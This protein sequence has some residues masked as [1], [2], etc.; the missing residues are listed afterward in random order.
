MNAEHHFFKHLAET[1]LPGWDIRLQP[2]MQPGSMDLASYD[3]RIYVVDTSTGWTAS[4]VMKASSFKD[5]GQTPARLKLSMDQ[6]K[7]LAAS[8]ITR[9]GCEQAE[10]D[11]PEV[12]RCI[13]LTAAALT[14][15]HTFDQVHASADLSGHWIY[16]AYR[17]HDAS[18]VARPVFFRTEATGVLPPEAIAQVVRQ[19]VA[20]DNSARSSHVGQ[21]IRRAGG[22]ILS[23]QF[24]SA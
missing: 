3:A 18:T 23:K 17:M 8:S 10:A 2:H 16:I 6:V 24:T 11:A 14:G 15:T 22:A 4:G 20:Q 21:M 19:V 13:E 12:A 1:T 7:D 9:L 5:A